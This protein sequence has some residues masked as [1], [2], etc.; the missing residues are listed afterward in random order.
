METT[1]KTDRPIGSGISYDDARGLVETIVS[2]KKTKYNYPGHDPDDLAQDI[3]LI[4]W[5]ALKKLDPD[6]LGK[7]VFHFVAKCVDNALY[8]KFRGVYLDNNP[9]C[10]R[11]PEYVKETKTCRIKE[12]GCS[13]IVQ[14]RDRMSRKRAI[15]APLSY[16]AHLDSDGDNDFSY[17]E[18][19]SVGST[20][21]VCDLDDSLRSALDPNLIAYYDL[22]IRGS[23]DDVPAHLRR[24]VQQQVRL[25]LD[26][27]QEI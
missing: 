20:T 25:I 8:N 16:N 19:L 4:C 26:E 11:C 9:P 5:E 2:M 3:R 24:L 22:M 6:K 7:S 12:V 10:L 23:G 18:S 1:V 21:G 14:Y 15:A 17:H 27:S 13:R